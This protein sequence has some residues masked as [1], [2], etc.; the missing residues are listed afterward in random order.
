M[1]P[2]DFESVSV[3]DID[4]N[5]HSATATVSSANGSTKS[6][7]ALAKEAPVS[8]VLAALALA[9]G[10]SVDDDEPVAQSM[11]EF[12]GDAPGGD[13]FNSAAKAKASKLFDDDSDEED[14]A[15]KMR[16]AK[17]REQLAKE[18][19]EAKAKATAA[20]AQA[21][22]AIAAEVVVPTSR[23]AHMQASGKRVAPVTKD[24]FADEDE[25]EA[26][27]ERRLGLQGVYVP[28]GAAEYHT[29]ETKSKAEEVD[30]ELLE[31]PNDD[32]L[33][34][35]GGLVA[36]SSSAAGGA[37]AGAG[38]AAVPSSATAATAASASA[39]DELDDDLFSFATPAP[40][41]PVVDASAPDFNFA[42]YISQQAAATTTTADKKGASLFDDDE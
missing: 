19:A 42:S 33:E 32:D 39:S 8:S 31:E 35:L 30:K 25:A 28:P 12:L 4:A 34:E 16:K 24:L 14:E 21:A 20:G 10:E 29:A 40:A 18:A 36:S 15:T 37:K 5:L 6:T 22:S 27:E 41:K 2:G 13:L 23:P 38:Y 11:A 1:N 17:R 3:D 26:A 9:A 7:L